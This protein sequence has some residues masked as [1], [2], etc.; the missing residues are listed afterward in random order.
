M[1][2]TRPFAYNPTSSIITGTTNIGTLCIGVSDL[3]YSANPGGLTW[4]MG[5]DEDNSYVIAKDVP[6]GNFPTPLG[7]IG[8]VQFWRTSTISDSGFIALA[9]ILTSQIFSDST[10]A[11][12]Y[13]NSNGY[14]TSF[15]SSVL[16]LD[17]YPNAAVA[18]SLRKIRTNYSGS[19]IRVRRSSDNVEYD[20][21]FVNDELDINF[22]TSIIPIN[23][24][25][26]SEDITNSSWLKSNLNVTGT[27]TYS[28]IEIAPNGNLTGDKII[29]NS[30]NS[31][32]S[33]S[34]SSVVTT[35][36]SDFNISVY[37][38][39]GERTKVNVISNIF[40]FNNPRTC[41][42]DL[43]NGTISNNNH[44]STPIVTFVG[45]GW[46]RF[47]VYIKS[48]VNTSSIPIRIQLLNELGENTYI[49]DGVSGC[50]VWGFQLSLDPTL[51]TY[52]KTDDVLRSLLVTTWYDQSGNE[53][54]ATQLTA[55]NQPRIANSGVIDLVNGK[56]SV[57]G[58]GSND[59]LR[60]TTLSLSNSVSTFVVVDKIGSSGNFGLFG[61]GAS[62]AG[63]FILTS[64]G[65]TFYQNGPSF[66]PAYA[67]NNQSLLVSKSTST[68]T[69]WE[70]YG[71]NTMV[72]NGE[73]NIGTA[74]GT[75]VSLF[76]RSSN[77]SRSNMYMQEYI[78]W[79]GNQM[80]NRTNI[81]NNINSF[82]SIY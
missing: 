78:V 3:N 31:I 9:Q 47:S 13:L 43:T 33:I 38:K 23:M 46:Y 64:T 65:F 26:F 15:E 79:N 49:G 68:G 48:S 16:L 4:W 81:Q 62:L 72:I 17:L 40:D 14:W 57:Y 32:H 25:T 70:L 20:I 8:N 61:S 2:T 71:N 67:N 44:Y 22:L 37:L 75:I 56:P 53:K 69:D 21:G 35:F 82:Y 45:N 19:A 55:V 28:N 27:P 7:N 42:V 54:H 41:T 36:N 18:Y 10:A 52:E 5:P 39:A 59:T 74:I 34:K 50:Y 76:D 58:D 80:N 51:K 66:S 73:E 6:S 60:N 24:W 30:T 63:A 11:K 77:V 29:E 1:A 12:T